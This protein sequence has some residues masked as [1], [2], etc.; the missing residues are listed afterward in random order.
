M[1]IWILIIIITTGIIAGIITGL[2]PGIHINLI[3]SIVLINFSILL[4]FI[5]I[6][7]IVIFIITMGVIH[8]FID[9]IPSIL[10]GVPSD[11]TALSVLP[12][13]KL[14]LDGKAYKAIFLSSV[15]SLSGMFFAIIF[16][17]LFYFTIE[18]LY[19]FFKKYVPYILITTS[20]L[21]IIFEKNN[22][23]RFWALIIATFSGALGM[24]ILNSTITNNPLLV[25][26]TGM[27]GISTM[28]S[29]LVNENGKI[30]KQNF[31]VDFK[32]NFRFIKAIF[33]GGCASS[34]CS[35]SP[36]LGNAQAGTISALFF[37]KI[38]SEIFIVVLSAINT[39]NFILSLI[40]FYLIDKARNGSIL[41]ISQIVEG[42]NIRELIFFFIIIFFVAIIG[43]NITLYLG[44]R[45]IKLIANLDMKKVNL[46]VM[47]LLFIMI[48]FITNWIGIII[49]IASASLGIL[50]INLGCRRVHLM[51]VLLLPVVLNLL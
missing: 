47:I 25:L 37:K 14:V 29:S 31:D 3:S 23:L 2:I 5:D 48:L 17:P 34:I 12:G 22:N 10:F 18:G 49:L 33:I 51:N 24:L 30:P 39:I 16:S 50:C 35:I 40:T 13:H 15:G 45:L 27:F 36:G 21:L 1:E 32:I 46:I 11:D 8:T 44:K 41:V 26:F 28:F 43:Y 19:T 38:S 20:I 42:I 7:A 9:F 4:N 6:R